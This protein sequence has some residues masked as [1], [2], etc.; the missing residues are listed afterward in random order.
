MKNDF[1]NN[2]K[3]YSQGSRDMLTD[4]TELCIYC[5]MSGLLVCVSLYLEK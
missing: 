5:K 4:R 2:F 3:G 1:A